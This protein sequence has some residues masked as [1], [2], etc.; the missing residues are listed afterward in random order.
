MIHSLKSRHSNRKVRVRNLSWAFC[1]FK[2]LNCQML[3]SNF[4]EDSL[5]KLTVICATPIYS[6]SPSSP[7]FVQYCK[8]QLIKYKSSENTPANVLDSQKNQ[9]AYLLINGRII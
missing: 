5:K 9:I 2:D 6:W 3:K 4:F 7:N 8:Y 1:I